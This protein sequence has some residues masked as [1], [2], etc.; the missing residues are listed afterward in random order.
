M[1]TRT[2]AALA[3]LV[4]S[5][6]AQTEVSPE[7]ALPTISE[8]APAPSAA[9]EPQTE[10]LAR[11]VPADPMEL[12]A[13]ALAHAREPAQCRFALS[14]H[15]TSASQAGLATSEFDVVTRF[16]PR[17]PVGD[18]W[19]VVSANRQQRALQRNMSREDRKGLPSDLILLLPE[20]EWTFENVA[21]AQEHPDRVVYNYTPRVI[22]ER[23]A[24]ETGVG[25]IEQLI[26]QFE[27][28]RE[29]GRIL[30]STLTE[31]PADAVR[32]LGIVRVHSALIVTQYAT[33]ANAFLLGEA[34]SQHLHLSALLTPTAV[35]TAF[36]YFDIEPI[37]DPAEV[38]RIA[39]EEAA[40]RD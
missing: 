11:V 20:G 40:A 13:F 38:A 10:A 3:V 34:G 7:A 17:L 31:P 4:T 28:S 19:T 5:A 18:R 16:D 24:S 39:E 22:P 30:K 27:V 32:A 15:A 9:V 23:A 29:S 37:C 6:W 33:G 1:I 35:G 2:L 25:I 8:A 12:A 21:V 36:R 26:G 14:R